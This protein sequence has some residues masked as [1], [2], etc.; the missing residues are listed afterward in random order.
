MA[1]IQVFQECCCVED[2]TPEWEECLRIS[3]SASVDESLRLF[4]NG[5]TSE[6]QAVCIVRAVIE[7]YLRSKYGNV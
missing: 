4:A 3:E 7:A 1:V 6:D 2:E 5:E